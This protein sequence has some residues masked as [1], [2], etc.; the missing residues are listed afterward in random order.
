MIRAAIAKAEGDHSQAIDLY[1]QTIEKNRYF[2][3]DVLPPLLDSATG[4]ID[5]L[6]QFDGS[7][8]NVGLRASRVCA[9][10]LLMPAIVGDLSGSAVLERCVE[11]F[12]LENEILASS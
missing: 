4:S 3:A 1:E 8:S 11:S 12:V 5:K 2:I 9:A 10:T 7:T 6:P